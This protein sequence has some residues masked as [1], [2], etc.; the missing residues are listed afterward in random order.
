MSDK[1]ICGIDVGS[2]KV[3]TIVA[4][5]SEK[6]NELRIIGFN[7]TSARGVKKGLI[8]DIDKVTSTIEES[9]EKAERMAGHKIKQAFVSVGGPHIAS[10]NSHGVVAVANPQAEINDNDVDR[11]IEAARAISLS[12]TRQIIEVSPRDFV[13]DGQPGIKNPVGMSGVRLEV[14]THL[15]TAS[16]TNLKNLERSLQALDI[17]NSGFV[18]SGLASAEAV[19]TDTEKELGAV[20]V[21]FG[22][23]KTD[24]CIYAEGALSYSASIPFGARHI[25]NDIAVGLRISLESAERVKLFLS[26]QFNHK[27]VKQIKKPETLNVSELQLPENINEISLKEL[28]DGIV[29][30]R[31]E[32]IYKFIG[33]EIV[34]SGFGEMVPAGLII[35]GGGALTVG[36]TETGRRVVGLPIRQGVPGRVA[37]LVDEVLDPQFATTVGLILYGKQNNTIESGSGKNFNQI[38]KNFTIGNSIGKLKDFFKQFIP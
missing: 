29:M 20:V 21:D 10:L 11:A 19:L 6:N 32:E 14:N 25:T 24:I 35:T 27:V 31:L 4:V 2:C 38:L 7:T 5:D 28:V 9:V 36:I 17:V 22:G 13:V 37:G 16:L 30:P 8:V 18:F 1:L 15:I 26:K 12:T 23:G 34:K 33:E 3:A